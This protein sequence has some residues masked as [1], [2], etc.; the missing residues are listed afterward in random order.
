MKNP[1]ASGEE[2][3][4][5]RR[6]HV[7]YFIN[8]PFEY[9]R[10]GN[11]DIRYGHTLNFSESGIMCAVQEQFVVGAQIEITLFCSDSDLM[12]IPMVLNV[13]WVGNQLAEDSFYHFGA[14]YT[15][16]RSEDMDSIR[17]FLDQYA[18]PSN[19]PIIRNTISSAA[20]KK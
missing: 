11:P 15:V 19:E 6:R 2:L 17:E 1:T 9:C 5:E 20:G 16:V 13:V 4:I 3:F 14:S 10:V 8:L 18:D 12:C 7:R